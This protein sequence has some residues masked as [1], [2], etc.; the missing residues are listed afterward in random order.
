MATETERRVALDG[1]V[2]A[3]AQF[4]LPGLNGFHSCQQAQPSILGTEELA[5]LWHLPFDDSDQPHLCRHSPASW[6]PRAARSRPTGI[7]ATSFSW[8]KPCT[9]T[10]VTWWPRPTAAPTRLD[11]GQDRHGKVHAVGEHD[12]GGHRAAAMASASLIRNGDLATSLLKRMPSTRTND[13]LDRSG[14][15]RFSDRL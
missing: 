14:R 6:F 7:R 11:R 4:D 12:L 3:F 13:D 2:A 5:T 1:I 9:A 8:A 10:I 15:K